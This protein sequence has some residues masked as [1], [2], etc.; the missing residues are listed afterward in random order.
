MN[1]ERAERKLATVLFADLVNSTELGAAQDPERTRT[2]LDRFY[3][4]MADEIS[5]AGG[6]VEK[7]AGDAVMAA[8]GV[9][10]AQED[11]VERALHAGLAMRRRLEE[12][13]GGALA[14]RI[15]VNTGEV[16]VGR[17]REDSS[18][19]TGDAVNVAA[20][21]E[22]AAEPGEILVGERAAVL[23]AG[24]FEFDAPMRV[25]A[26]GKPGG[27]EC[28]R[29]VRALALLR[30]RGVL[31]LPDAFVGRDEELGRLTQ[32]HDRAYSTGKPQVVTIMGEAGVGKT[33][34][35]RELWGWYGTEAPEVI[36]RTGRCPPYGRA[37][38]YQAVGEILKE[39]FGIL[40]SDSP[41]RVL[42]LLAHR[43]ILAL[44]L[45]LDA[46][47]DLHPI[48]AR[49][50]LQDAWIEL[51]TEVAAEQPLALI[52]ED[53]HWAEE[54]LLELLERM[55]FEVDARSCCSSRAVPS[56]S[57][58]ARPGGGGECRASGSGSSH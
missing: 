2:M 39:H 54:L 35:L 15:G 29:L 48:E 37:R 3:E 28:R 25:E 13:F 18:F 1:G 32:A 34:L 23:V 53:V 57:T 8:F 22:Q 5:R 17:P 33:R 50:R 58:G 36:R 47:A 43:E 21:L 7:F 16:V 27:V 55:L 9:P 49:D 38:T 14:L 56:F 52:V 26:K 44:A 20:R 24:A 12:L 31:G 42:S 19:V 46:T 6:R 40:D 10:A 45:G 4:A 30:P 41:E 11:H 51:V